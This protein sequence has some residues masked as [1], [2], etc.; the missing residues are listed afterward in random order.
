MFGKERKQEPLSLLSKY[1]FENQLE[2]PNNNISKL[3]KKQAEYFKSRVKEMS[4]N[5]ESKLPCSLKAVENLQE[6]IVNG[7]SK[8][9]DEY[10]SAM[11]VPEHERRLIDRKCF[12]EIE[13][14]QEIL[15]ESYDKKHTYFS[16]Q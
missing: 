14:H 16:N 1:N 9:R 15:V 4:I 10:S 2:Y 3:R 8:L 13:S 12:H 6:I 5:I 7:T 11:A